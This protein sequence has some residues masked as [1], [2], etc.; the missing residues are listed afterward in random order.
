MEASGG[1]QLVLSTEGDQDW[2]EET[3]ASPESGIMLQKEVEKSQWM[4]EQIWDIGFCVYLLICYTLGWII[5][6]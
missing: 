4:K 3:P 1:E 2:L 6:L 5:S